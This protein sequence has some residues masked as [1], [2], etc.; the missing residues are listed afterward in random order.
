MITERKSVASHE[1]KRVKRSHDES[2]LQIFS[3]F[4]ESSARNRLL[5]S[6]VGVRRF[7]LSFL[8]EIPLPG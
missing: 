2:I 4:C 5:P 7:F 1:A 8:Y 6:L 3:D